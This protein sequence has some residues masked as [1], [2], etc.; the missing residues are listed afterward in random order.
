MENISI[1]C[2]L[3]GD[4]CGKH[5]FKYV[6]NLYKGIYNNTDYKFRFICFTDHDKKNFS[7]EIEVHNLAL[8]YER[9]LKKMIIY[10]PDNGLTGQIFAFDLDQIINGN[11]N[12][13]LSY[14]G[15]FG[16]CEGVYNKRKGKCG[17]SLVSF[18]AGE[19]N[20]LWN[21]L[22]KRKEK[23]TKG[24]E[25]FYYEMFDIKMDF[26]QRLY[27]NQ[28]HSFKVERDKINENTRIIWFHGKPKPHELGYMK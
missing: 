4:W 5:K 9:N 20:Y 15:N 8:D 6:H 25:R 24:K 27:P 14:K 13:I 26:F 3:W 1:V 21:E 18:P 7:S 17:G 2:F 28:I 16:I 11:L 10:K 22:D 12:D 19:H 23:I